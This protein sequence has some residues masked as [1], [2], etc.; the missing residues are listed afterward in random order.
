MPW[1]AAF[2]LY[3]FKTSSV[4]RCVRTLVAF[5]RVYR[6]KGNFEMFFESF[7]S[8]NTMLQYSHWKLVIE[9]LV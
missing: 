6:Q 3:V 8:I 1:C 2:L 5:C 7:L 4:P 9:R